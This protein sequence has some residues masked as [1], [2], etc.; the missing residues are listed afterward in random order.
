MEP[1]CYKEA[2]EELRPLGCVGAGAAVEA[3]RAL[4]V[5]VDSISI[6][7]EP[8]GLPAG[9]AEDDEDEE[10]DDDDEPPKDAEPV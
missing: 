2:T 8:C 9:A 1:R 10:E 3:D 5:V 6:A 7:E 4:A